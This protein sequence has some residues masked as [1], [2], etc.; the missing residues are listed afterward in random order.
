MQ[1]HAK[2]LEVAAALKPDF[3]GVVKL[4]DDLHALQ[5]C[6]RSRALVD[7]SGLSMIKKMVT[8]MNALGVA[9]GG[10]LPTPNLYTT[11]AEEARTVHLRQFGFIIGNCFVF[12]RHVCLTSWRA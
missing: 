8:R 10:L 7:L 11:P 2:F 12:S 5:G 1:A 6:M 3:D 4:D 9:G